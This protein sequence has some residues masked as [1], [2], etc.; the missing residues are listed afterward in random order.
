MIRLTS[1]FTIICFFVVT[2]LEKG[3]IVLC[4]LVNCGISEPVEAVTTQNDCSSC[5]KSQSACGSIISSAT[6]PVKV[7]EEKSCQIFIDVLEALKKRCDCGLEAPRLVA[8]FEKPPI[9]NPDTD[10]SHFIK[11]DIQN[12]ISACCLA[13]IAYQRGVN[14]IISTTVL[15]L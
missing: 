11:L 14:P 3:M 9:E 4:I 12:N 1:L 2:F 5:C 6:T 15:R 7:I 8:T 10:C 13:D